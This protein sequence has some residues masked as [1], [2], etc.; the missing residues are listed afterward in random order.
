MLAEPPPAEPGCADSPRPAPA[1]GGLPAASSSLRLREPPAAPSAELSPAPGGGCHR[2]PCV[3]AAGCRRS[4]AG[5]ARGQ[6]RGEEGA[7]PPGRFPPR[8]NG[9]GRRGRV[10]GA[11]VERVPLRGAGCERGCREDKAAAGRWGGGGSPPW[12]AGRSV[13][14][15]RAERGQGT[16]AAPGAGRQD[17][18]RAGPEPSLLR[19][20]LCERGINP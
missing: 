5:A 10:P 17:G 18:S 19:E 15:S 8:E 13:G 9:E 3:S 7:A 14:R 16:A 12:P 2:R 1:A 20:Q 6:G 11:A 4:G